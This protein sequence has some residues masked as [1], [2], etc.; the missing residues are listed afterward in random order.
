MKKILLGLVVAVFVGG[1]IFSIYK[2]TNKITG[3]TEIKS[4]S[5]VD[6]KKG[7]IMVTLGVDTC[8]HCQNFK[9]VMNEVAQEKQVEIYY[10]DANNIDDDHA[11]AIP[12][13]CADEANQKITDGFGT[14]LTLFLKDNKVVDCISGEVDAVSLKSKLRNN[15]LIK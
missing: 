4:F 15:E 13:K 1:A 8:S 3:Y 12:L 14:P 2:S 6:N 7:T 10:L 5:E 9:K 11:Y